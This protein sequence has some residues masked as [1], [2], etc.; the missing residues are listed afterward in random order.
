[1]RTSAL[2][3]N[4]LFLTLVAVTLLTAVAGLVWKYTSLGDTVSVR[5]TMDWLRHSRRHWW[6]PVLIVLAYVPGSLVMFPP[7][8]LITIASVVA[9]GPWKAFVLAMIGVQIPSIAAYYAGRLFDDES[10]HR[11]AGPR[12]ASGQ[13]VLRKRGL[14]AFQALRLLTIAP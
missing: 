1:M 13:Y 7:R 6:A 11:L 12:L 2:L 9:F 4:P 8:P 3:R 10:V 5:G 14:M